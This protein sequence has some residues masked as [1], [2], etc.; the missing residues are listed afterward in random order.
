MAVIGLNLC[1]FAKA[2]RVRQA[3]R[4]VCSEATTPAALCADLLHELQWLMAADPRQI[5]TTLLIH[6]QVLGDFLDFNDFLEVADRCLDEL[7]LVG[8]IQIASF[9][10]QYRFDGTDA[11]AIENH[12]NRSPFPM[13]HLL[14]EASVEQAVASHPD[15]ARIY[16]RNIDTLRRLGPDGWQRLFARR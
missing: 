8:E 14:R 16:E 12:T 7:G 3:I 15:A 2:V 9:H 1:P 5:E 13:L 6:P 11:Q 4:T 10:P